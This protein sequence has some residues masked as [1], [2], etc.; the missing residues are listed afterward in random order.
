MIPTLLIVLS[1]DSTPSTTDLTGYNDADAVILLRRSYHNGNNLI[2]I[3]VAIRLVW[4][5]HLFILHFNKSHF[6]IGKRMTEVLEL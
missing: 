1:I 3:F 6:Y 5:P 4:Q 2:L